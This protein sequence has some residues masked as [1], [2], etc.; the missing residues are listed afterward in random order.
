VSALDPRLA[1]IKAW[2]FSVPEP[3]D[4]ALSGPNPTQRGLDP[5]RGVRFAYVEVLDHTRRPVLYIQGSG[6]L[7]WRFGLT[8]D[9]LVYISFSG[10]VAGPKPSTWWGQ[11]LLL[12]QGSHPKLGRVTTWPNTYLLYQVAKDSRVGTA[13]SYSSKGYPSF[14]VLAS[15][16]TKRFLV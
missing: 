13:S 16:L 14:R 15:S 10:Y 2:V 5:I 6:T 1:L 4:P 7:P 12:V 9:A 11:E 8:D 3:R